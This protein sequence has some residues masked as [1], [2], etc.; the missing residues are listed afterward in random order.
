MRERLTAY[1]SN[2]HSAKLANLP[3]PFFQIVEGGMRPAVVV[4]RAIGTIEI[5]MI[6]DIKTAL[7]RFAIEQTLARFQ[8]IVAGKFTADVFQNLHAALMRSSV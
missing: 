2:A 6:R 3:N 5:A 4:L 8:N 1:E 7:Q